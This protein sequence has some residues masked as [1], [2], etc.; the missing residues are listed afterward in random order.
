MKGR[1]KVHVQVVFKNR[2]PA[3]QADAER[4]AKQVVKRTT[5]A[6]NA[7]AKSAMAQPKSG[8]M[9]GGHQASAAG[10]APAIDM[11]LLVNSLSEDY[12]TNGLTGVAFTNVMY[13][14]L[15]EYGGKRIRP[16]PFFSPAAQAAKRQ[17]IAEMKDIYEDGNVGL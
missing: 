15:L 2:F 4:A 14:E 13:A 3:I 10:E 6:I 1:G 9:Y 11:G 7:Y 16:R 5:M 12:E 17:F 8:R